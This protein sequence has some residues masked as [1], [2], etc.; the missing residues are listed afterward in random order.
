MSQYARAIARVVGCDEATCGLIE[1]AAPMHDVGKI[2]IEDRILRKPGKLTDEEFAAMKQ[3]PVIGGRI[4]E[5]DDPLIR[6]GRE[7]ALTH[8]EKWDGSGYPNGLSGEDIPLAGRV[9]AVA[10]VFDA[11]MTKRPYKEPWP[12]EKAIALIVEG[13]D[14]AF[15]PKV[16]AAFQEA[17]PEILAI[18]ARYQDDTINPGDVLPAPGTRVDENAWLPW[19]DSYSVGIGVIDEHHRY[20]FDWA[21]RA[22]QAVN[23]GAGMVEI[24]KA[25]FA[26]EQYA[27][28]HFRA[29]ERLMAAHDHAGLEQHRQQHRSF[30]AELRELREEIGHNPFVAGMGMVEYLRDWLFDHILGTDKRSFAKL[31]DRA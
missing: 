26:L 17:L 6:M 13:A 25:L 21:N 20:L 5:G 4:L 24:A 22:Y 29:E 18:K 14:K 3:H 10:D 30:E 7:I 9:C 28:I 1:L 16:V 12:L 8:H 23:E 19:R 2:G 27:R 31:A 15:D 11:L